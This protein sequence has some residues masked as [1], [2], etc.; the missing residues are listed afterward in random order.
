M[1]GRSKSVSRELKHLR[2]DISRLTEAL[3]HELP[4]VDRRR[5]EKRVRR[6]YDDAAHFLGHGLDRLGAN[7]GR[8]VHDVVH[9]ARI[10]AVRGLG[11]ARAAVERNPLT[12]VAIAGAI[13]VTIGALLTRRS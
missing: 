8:L 9:E 12:A 10:G 3:R 13:A 6:N 4:R 2:A 1:L 11:E 5:M 7:G